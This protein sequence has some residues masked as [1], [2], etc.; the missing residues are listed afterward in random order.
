[1]SR[2]LLTLMVH[3]TSIP[4]CPILV[5]TLYAGNDFQVL[6]LAVVLVFNQEIGGLL[7]VW[8]QGFSVGEN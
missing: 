2:A 4:A 5:L 1:M 3:S 6:K 8:W 7:V